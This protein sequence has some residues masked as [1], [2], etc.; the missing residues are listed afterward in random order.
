LPLP[1]PARL[2]HVPLTKDNTEITFESSQHTTDSEATRYSSF[3]ESVA[4]NDKL[5]HRWEWR[6][7]RVRNHPVFD[8]VVAALGPQGKFVPPETEDWNVM[9]KNPRLSLQGGR[10][11]TKPVAKGLGLAVFVALLVPVLLAIVLVATIHT[12]VSVLSGPEDFQQM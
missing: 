3:C 9:E 8:A 12:K 4:L 10:M 7:K 2:F 6:W 1:Y 5:Q 11:P